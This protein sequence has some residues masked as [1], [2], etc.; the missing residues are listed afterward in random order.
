[1][2]SIVLV[3]EASSDS[4]VAADTLRAAHH[5]VHTCCETAAAFECVRKTQPDLVILNLLATDHRAGCQVLDLL[6]HQPETE[7]IPV[8]LATPGLDI[9]RRD[10]VTLMEHGVHLVEAQASPAR[11][12]ARAEQV[13][14]NAA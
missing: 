14:Q 2:P 12:A 8:L 10:A 9:V 13:L 5:V 3:G 4:R 6:K 1:M 11:L 7:A